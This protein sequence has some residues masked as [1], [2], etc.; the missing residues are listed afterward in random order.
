MSSKLNAFLLLVGLVLAVPVAAPAQEATLRIAAIVNQDVISAY[1]LNSRLRMVIASSHLDPSPDVVKRLTPQVMHMLID[2]KLKLQAAK[3]AD[4]QVSETEVQ[5]AL[6][7]IEKQNNIPPGQLDT[8]LQREGISVEELSKQVRADIAWAKTVQRKMSGQATVT[9]NE[10]TQTLR[11]VQDSAG[12]P[13]N[14]VSEIFLSVDSPNREEEVQQLAERMIQ[15]LHEG[16][17]FPAL[18]RSFS[19]S[20]SSGVGGDLGWVRPGQLADEV[21]S[22]IDKMK[23]GDLSDPI[24]SASGYNIVYL[25]ERRLNPGIGGDIQ[26][27]NLAQLFF[28]IKP[29]ATQAQIDSEM[30]Q[31]QQVSARMGTCDDMEREGRL[32]GTRASGRVGDVRLDNLP[33]PIRAIVTSLP[34]G[35]ASDP[36]RFPDGITVLMVCSRSTEKG[37]VDERARVQQMLSNQRMDNASRQYL[38]D[39]RRAAIVDI[40]L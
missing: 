32:M 36:Q 5:N 1:D 25:H 15:Q 4:I 12:K 19:Q 11:E 28:E 34:D 17:S 10:I 31:A 24:R 18:A 27:V 40:R 8:Y 35:K 30:R 39:L 7:T 20:S 37:D 13:E 22:A 29:N 14:H 26:M 21:E 38:R 16:A 9:E 23:P 33:P 2:E 3:D 6:T